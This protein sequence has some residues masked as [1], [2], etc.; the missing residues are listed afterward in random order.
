MNT[1]NAEVLHIKT[2]AA[3]IRSTRIAASCLV[4]G[5]GLFVFNGFNTL[6]KLPEEKLTNR[7]KV[8]FFYLA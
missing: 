4:V 3:L 7:L 6:N 5:V 1:E 8:L 2:A